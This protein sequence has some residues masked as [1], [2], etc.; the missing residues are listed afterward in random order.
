[1]V[2]I[3][4]ISKG[5]KSPE[6]PFTAMDIALD[7][8]IRFVSMYQMNVLKEHRK[9]SKF[10]STERAPHCV[11]GLKAELY[12]LPTHTLTHFC[13]FYARTLTGWIQVQSIQLS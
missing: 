7:I 9:S 1:M 4:V 5:I 12:Y 11:P 10:A 2:L 8:K 3:Y 13:H 6:C